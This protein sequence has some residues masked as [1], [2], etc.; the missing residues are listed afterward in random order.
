MAPIPIVAFLNLVV[1]SVGANSFVL[2][3]KV[4]SGKIKS[5]HLIEI[6]LLV[7]DLLYP[8]LFQPMVVMTCFG[9]DPEWLFGYFG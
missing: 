7:G 9:Y 2:V 1:V 4:K 5:V 8:L 6:A 3:T